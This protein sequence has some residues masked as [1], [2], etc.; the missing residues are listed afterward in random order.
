MI[1]KN[2]KYRGFSI[3]D[4][5]FTINRFAMQD[6]TRSANIRWSQTPFANSFGALLWPRIA[7][8][9]VFELSGRI[10][11]VDPRIREAKYA[12]LANLFHIESNLSW[13][14]P[15]SFDLERETKDGKKRVASCIVFT[16]LEAENGLCDPIVERTVQLVSADPRIYDPLEVELTWWLAQ[17]W[18][19]V[20]SNNLAN[21]NDDNSDWSIIANHEW[22]RE[23]P[24]RIRV[25]WECVNPR[26]MVVWE[27]KLLY[28]LRIDRTTTDLVVDTLN[29]VSNSNNDRFILTD[30]GINIKWSRKRDR[31][32]W[33][34]FLGGK[35]ITSPW[36]SVSRIY[37]LWENFSTN[38]CTVTVNYRHTYSF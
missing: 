32:W 4:A 29:V 11:E 27:W 18:W 38:N 37:V 28:Y 22:D 1:G 2:I 31:W 24:L 5:E 26:I 35:S 34:L 30:N 21:P 25:Q 20:L 14:V 16:P 8:T 3:A 36:S 13:N 7:E 10:H 17:A 23:A 12:E 19:N 15:N 33:P 9:R 6:F